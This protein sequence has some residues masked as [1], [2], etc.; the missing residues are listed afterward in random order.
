MIEIEYKN[1]NIRY[2]GNFPC[3]TEQF[4]SDIEQ[5][6]KP[7]GVY[8]AICSRDDEMFLITDHFG[9][10]PIWYTSQQASFYFYDLPKQN[11]SRNE[12]FFFE[13][14]MLGGFTVSNRTQYT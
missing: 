3:S 6:K 9:S 2:R 1:W 12:Q 4:V 14:D 8:G 5:G 7:Q 11:L 10:Y 13:R